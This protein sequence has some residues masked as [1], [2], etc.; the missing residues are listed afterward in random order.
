MSLGGGL[1]VLAGD[2]LGFMVDGA[3]VGVDGR[4]GL[5][6]VGMKCDLKM[7]LAR[8]INRRLLRCK[9]EHLRHTPTQHNLC[10]G[11]RLACTELL[12]ELDKYQRRKP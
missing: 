7:A 5:V 8:F 9:R 11:Y 4:V 12:E 2:A 6:G 3:V 10:K 1:D